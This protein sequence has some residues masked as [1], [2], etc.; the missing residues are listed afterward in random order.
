MEKELNINEIMNVQQLPIIFQQLE[1]VGKY[2]DEELEKV[3]D[4]ECNE[5]N[6]NEV[7]KVRANINA[8]LKQ[9]EDARKSI[10]N[11]VLDAYNQFNDK[12]EDEVKT[13]LQNAS[14]ELKTK[15]DYIEKIQLQEKIDELHDFV[16]EHIS[17][18]HLENMLDL[19]KVVTYGNLKVNLSTSLKSL[20]ED[21]KA[22]IERI[23]NEVKLIE[24][25]E[26]PS[27]LLYEY[28][29]NGFD[30]TKAKLTLIERQKQIEEL[31][32]Q[33]EQ[34]Q[35]V[36]EQ[37]EQVAEVVEEITMPKEI[38]ATTL[39]DKEEMLIVQFT[40]KGSKTQI[41][42]LKEFIKELGVEYE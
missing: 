36:V 12:Y 23:A 18:N 13:K 1:V 10:K 39:E 3:K 38:V 30:L 2:V 37:E 9:F 42:K 31:A 40:V 27:N 29:N 24:M 20:K 8:T 33:R 4:L 25:E 34:V 35:E 14:E 15:I 16:V 6:K 22:F 41:I 21:A 32:K 17:T 28:K 19:D 26:T 7:K 5:E 11:Q